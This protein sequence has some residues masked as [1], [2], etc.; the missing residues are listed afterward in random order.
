MTNGDA[1]K[2]GEYTLKERIEHRER[3]RLQKKQNENFAEMSRLLAQHRDNAK[4]LSESFLRL[5]EE[6]KTMK[7][8]E[9]DR[10]TPRLP[11]HRLSRVFSFLIKN[12]PFRA[13]PV[14][15]KRK[16]GDYGKITWS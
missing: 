4:K 6:Y 8:P 16:D 14:Q 5:R 15:G 3:E 10:R 12:S 2:Q 1:L 13:R 11:S 9:P 7:P